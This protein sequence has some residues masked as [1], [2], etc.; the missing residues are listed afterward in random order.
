MGFFSSRATDAHPW[1]K[2]SQSTAIDSLLEASFERPQLVFK[3]STRCSISAWA[4]KDFERAWAWDN[5]PAEPHFLDLI[6]HRDVSNY[7]AEVSGVIHQSPQVLVFRD[8]T[9]IYHASHQAID[10]QEIMKLLG[11]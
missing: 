11:V 2:V 3:H 4:L 9:C 7:V 8:G 6:A 10:A 1:N 5:S